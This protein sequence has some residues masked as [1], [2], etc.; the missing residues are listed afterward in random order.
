MN[1]FVVSEGENV[2]RRPVSES[3]KAVMNENIE[4]NIMLYMDLKG[5]VRR[6]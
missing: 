3:V 2:Y 6:M 5:L 1:E 4:E